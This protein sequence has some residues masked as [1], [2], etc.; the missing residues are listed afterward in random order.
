MNQRLFQVLSLL[1]ISFGAGPVE[2]K[3]YVWQLIEKIPSKFETY[4]PQGLVKIGDHFYLASVE[5]KSKD[6]STGLGHL[7]EFDLTGNLLRQITL[8]E[9]AIF[10]PG[11]IDFDGRLL[12]VPVAEYRPRSRAIL[13][14]IDPA[15]M[16]AKEAFRVD[17]HIG[18]VVFNREVGTV[19]GMNWDAQA[20]YEWKPEGGLIR[21][22]LNEVHEYSYQDCK[23]LE[24]PAMLCSGTRANANGGIAVVDLLDFDLIQDIQ[25]VPRTRKKILMTRNPMAIEL[26]GGVLRYYFLPEDHRG[27]LYVFEIH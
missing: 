26:T 15:T 13:Y 4:H 7:F 2:A 23:Y 27:D 22:V 14:K 3:P 25:F 10:H 16:E 19:V 8:G 21:K 6:K 20:F 11:G 9:G 18:A 17:D 5:V 1:L 12:W 24:G